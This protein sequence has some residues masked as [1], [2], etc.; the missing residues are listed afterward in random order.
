MAEVIL[1]FKLM[2]ESPETNWET[3][4]PVA[5]KL[6]EEFDGEIG[7]KEIRP[8][9]FGLTALHLWV[10]RDESRGSADALEKKLAEIEG[11]RSCEC[12]DVRRTLG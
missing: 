7:K 9:A 6:V 5:N 8:I 3:V 10:V 11:V 1:T 12:I 4:E 2:G